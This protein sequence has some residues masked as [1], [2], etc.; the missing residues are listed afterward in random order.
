MLHNL[1]AR[2]WAK[3]ERGIGCH[4]DRIGKF[5]DQHINRIGYHGWIGCENKPATTTDAGIA[6]I[7]LYF[8]S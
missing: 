1:P 3:G 2:N 8:G 4:P 6:W 5:Q 7:K